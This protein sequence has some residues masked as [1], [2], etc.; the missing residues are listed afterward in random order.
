M[1]TTAV[2]PPAVAG[3]FYPANAD[4]LGEALRDSF[5][6]AVDDDGGGGVP[7]AIVAPHAG[8]V[9]SGPV[10]A[11]AYRRLEAG[12]GTITR[13]VLLGPS[14]RVA[15]E[16]MAVP[17]VDALATPL[18]LVALDRAGRHTVAALAGVVVADAPH[19]LEHSLEVHLPFLQRVLGDVEV[20]PIVVGHA[21]ALQVADV[22]DAV[23]GGP[24]T[25]IVVSTDLSHYH[26]HRTAQVLDRS[27]AEAVVAGR[28]D[29][30]GD[31]SACG[32]YPLRGLLLAAARHGLTGQII[33]LRTSGDTAGPHDRVVGYGAFLF[34]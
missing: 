21:P 7:K 5:A 30:I 34:S 29:D 23:W 24:E 20:L 3:M 8:Y 26:D 18:G 11:S 33:D 28:G 15:L 10:A 16:G 25:L 9:Y 1:T 14:H 13:V 22:L 27:T 2:R 19:A 32:A 12:R 31:R 17:S 6:A 4:E